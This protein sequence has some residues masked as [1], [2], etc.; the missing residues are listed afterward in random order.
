MASQDGTAKPAVDPLLRELQQAPYKY[1]FYTAMRL[2]EC[3]FD[4]APRLGRSARLKEEPVRLSQEPSL[5]FA[6]TAIAGFELTENRRH[7]LSVHFFGLCGPNGALPLHLTEYIR[8]RIRHHDDTAFAAFL[9]IFHHR[10]LT[11]FYR[12]WADS[13][14]T[15]NFD[16]PDSDRFAVYLGAVFG[17]GTPATRERDA[18][19]DLAKLA[20]A[21]RLACQTRHPEGLQAMIADFFKLPVKIDEFLG[22]WVEL[23]EYCRFGLGDQPDSATLG[24]ACTLG[25]HVWDCQQKFRITIGPVGW[26]DFQRMLPGGDSMQRL[27]A[28]V[29]NYIGDELLWE[30]NLVLKQEETPSWQLGEGQLGQSLWMDSAGVRLDPADVLLQPAEAIAQ[31]G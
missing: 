29:R 26:D 5:K 27:I 8:D 17:L 22:A 2:L 3:I 23:P 10:L 20:Y 18:L 12:A 16:R 14:P 9:D 1:D 19:P 31:A 24:V 30:L 13:Q 15:V 7:Q 11:L 25:S 21:G 4:D 6:P 28:L